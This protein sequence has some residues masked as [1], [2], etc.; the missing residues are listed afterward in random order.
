MTR[1]ARL[2]CEPLEDRSV[3]ALFGNAWPNAEKLTLSFA[4]DGTDV[5]GAQSNLF[6]TLNAAMPTAAWQAEIVRAFQTWAAEGNVNVSVVSDNGS[7][8]GTAGPVQGS[9][10]YGDV[11]VSARPLSDNVLAVSTPFNVFNSWSGEIVLNSNKLFG[12]GG[13]DGRFDLFTVALQETGHALGLDNSPDPASAMF[14]TYTAARTGLGAGDVASIQKLYGVRAADRF[15]ADG[16]NDLLTAATAITYVKDGADLNGTD[17]TV[18]DKPLVAA[19][20][21]STLADVDY[22]AFTAPKGSSDFFVAATTGGVLKAKITVYGPDGRAVKFKNEANGQEMTSITFSATRENPLYIKVE[23]VRGGATYRVAIEGATEDV[24][25]IGEYRLAVG[26]E[27]W[28]AIRPE[29]PTGLLNRD[30]GSNDSRAAATLL[31]DA[32]P[33]A[34]ARWDFTTAASLQ[35]TTDV[36]FYRVRTK[37]DTPVAAVLLVSAHDYTALSPSLEVYDRD[38]RRVPVEV[39][40]NTGGTVVVQFTGVRPDT[41]Y[42]VRVAAAGATKRVGNYTL[43]VDFR[44][45]VIPLPTFAAGTFAGATTQA[46]TTFAVTRSQS[47]YFEVAGTGS[48]DAAVRMTVYDANHVAVLTLVARG[49][50]VSARDILLA[51]G[52][53]TVRFV[54]A[55][56]DGS[57]LSGFEFRGRYSL[58]TDP[59]GPEPIDTT[60]TAP[61]TATTVPQL[62]T[63]QPVTQATAFLAPST[64]YTAPVGAPSTAPVVWLAPPPP[65]TFFISVRTDIYSTPW[66]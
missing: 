38:G 64:T 61:T 17:G 65:P 52:T 35:S 5:A 15:D 63:Y 43:A 66:W 2:A 57:P 19:A 45:A 7:A 16:P 33:G 34:D 48:A 20:D 36:D 30:N 9:P 39:L 8:F 14:T 24:F 56:R 40:S 12:R 10:F 62:Y 23:N 41:D 55:N 22:Y 50:E 60:G 31:G 49:G 27:A 42:F 25:G 13:A 26:H 58:G 1:P 54:A 29:L 47:V 18:G 53:Y 3:P 11:R 21:L 51:P 37:A 28:E 44:D 59:I 32:L 4:P 46:A 6:R